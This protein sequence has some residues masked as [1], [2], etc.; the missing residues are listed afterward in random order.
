M[1]CHAGKPLPIDSQRLRAHHQVGTRRAG[2]PPLEMGVTLLVHLL[3][4][5][6]FSAN[7]SMADQ[8]DVPWPRKNI[9]FGGVCGPIQMSL[10]EIIP[11]EFSFEMQG[12]YH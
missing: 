7:G 8:S 4:Q 6:H 12:V 5:A 10:P 9:L 11:S 2:Q 3:M 1:N